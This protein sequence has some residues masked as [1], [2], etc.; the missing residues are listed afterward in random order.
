MM[1]L[2]SIFL[3]WLLAILA[4]SPVGLWLL[5]QVK[6]QQPGKPVH[7][8]ILATL[9]GAAINATV[10]G[11]LSL[12]IPITAKLSL[13]LAILG[14]LPFVPQFLQGCLTV[15]FRI[16]LWSVSSWLGFATLAFITVKL[17]LHT[18][19]NNDSGLYYIQFMNWINS[20]SVIP[21][22]AN[23]HDRLGFNSHWHLLNAAYNM[24][25]LG[26]HA[27]N[28]L[29]G[30][31]FILFG[32]GAFQAANENVGK[33]TFGNTVW[34]LLP[35]S[36]FLLARFVTSAAPDLPAAIIPMVYLTYLVAQKEKSSLPVLIGLIA[37]T[38]TIKVLSV[39]HI[40]A[41]LPLLYLTLAN[42]DF[43][44]ILQT[45]LIGS[46]IAAP[47]LIRNV[48]QTGY[49]VFPMESIDLFSYD[50]KVPQQLAANTRMMID[51]HARTGS[52]DLTEYGKPMTF[53][54]DTWRSAQS[55]SVIAIIMLVASSS[56]LII[57]ASFFKLAKK[58]ISNQVF[59]S[60]SLALTLQF[61]IAFWWSTGPNPRFIYA[62][63]LFFLA[64]SLAVVGIALK[65]GKWMRFAPLLALIPLLVITRTVLKESGP[66][67]PTEFSSMLI[68][69]R[70]V[71]Y[72][73]STDKC[74]EHELPCANMQRT[75]LR[76]R[77]EKIED[78]FVNIDSGK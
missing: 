76:F 54:F 74:W 68:N 24:K 59:V 71:Y 32:L 27:T 40:L 64:Y 6:G 47:W 49:L 63:V 17:S 52:Y 9:L 5:S 12:I 18:S 28:D 55:K 62:I 44:T 8:F 26:L 10:L 46:L 3:S 57:L 20:Y 65:L 34:V 58:R 36:L 14:L 30:L 31:L 33:N 72:P 77:G 43:K 2:V 73:V 16:R 56:V 38:T 21:G 22:L 41:I 60:I 4:W 69:G 23:L 50:W 78:G 35:I 70:P 66:T 48:I 13:W 19:L 75:D 51:T 39:I 7:D 45:I 37:F 11:L 1:H 29:N 42:K 25:T 61:S 53:W 15:A 67:R